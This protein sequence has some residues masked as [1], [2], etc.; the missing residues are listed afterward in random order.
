MNLVIYI[1]ELDDG[2]VLADPRRE[3][4]EDLVREGYR[5][6]PATIAEVLPKIEA[7]VR[8]RDI[9]DR[10]EAGVMQRLDVDYLVEDEKS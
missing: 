3:V 9:R 10:L 2:T 5:G 8:A 6:Q 1:V 4:V 7:Y